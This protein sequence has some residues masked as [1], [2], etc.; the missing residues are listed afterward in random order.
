MLVNDYIRTRLDE[1]KNLLTNNNY[2]GGNLLVQ[3]ESLPSVTLTSLPA[4]NNNIGDVDIVT[5]PSVTV[6]SLPAGTNNIGDVDVVTMPNVKPNALKIKAV[7]SYDVDATAVQILDASAQSGMVSVSV[8][9]AGAENI[10]VYHTNSVTNLLFFKKLASGENW[11]FPLGYTNDATNDLYA[12]RASAQTDD[13][14]VVT[15]WEEV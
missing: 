11:E 7:N 14:V 2:D 10:Y 1:I 9:N 12:I 15:V 4:G 3:I 13:N 8:C 5:M 6:N